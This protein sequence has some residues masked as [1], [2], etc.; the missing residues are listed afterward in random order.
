MLVWHVGGPCPRRGC[1][2]CLIR[3]RGSSRC[4]AHVG[5]GPMSGEG[6]RRGCAEA[7]VGVQGTDPSETLPGQA[8][9][10]VMGGRLRGV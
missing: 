1:L 10:Q 5:P 6:G 9:G 8:P 7:V 4:R 3:V 2:L